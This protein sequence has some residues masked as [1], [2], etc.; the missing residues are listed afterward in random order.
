SVMEFV[1]KELGIKT[2]DRPIDRSELYTADELFF[3]GTGAQIASITDVDKRPIGDG[4]P[5]E[6]TS[7]IRDIYWKICHGEL[8][9]YQKWLTPAYAKKNFDPKVGAEAGRR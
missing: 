1:H 3:C 8:R 2:I 9:D 7:K 6:L 4:K 5:G